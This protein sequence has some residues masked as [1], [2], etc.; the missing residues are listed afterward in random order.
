[1]N[2]SAEFLKIPVEIFGKYQDIKISQKAFYIF[3]LPFWHTIQYYL[4][5]VRR[6]YK[7]KKKV[8][9]SNFHQIFSK[10]FFGVFNESGFFFTLC[11]EFSQL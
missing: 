2:F 3:F 1:M 5:T 4:S 10:V 8:H 7:M 11:T 6:L 9:R